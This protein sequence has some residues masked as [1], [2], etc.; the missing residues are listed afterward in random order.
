[1]GINEH[2][3][4]FMDEGW[5]TAFENLIGKADLGNEQA[6]NFFKQFRVAGWA[7]NPGDETQVPIIT[8]VNILSGQAMGHN[9]YGKPALAYLALK[10]MLGD[11]VFRKCLHGFMDRWN[12]KHPVPWDMFNS[13]T[14]LAGK[15]LSWYFNNWFFT[16]NYMD[17][18]ADKVLPT[19]TG[20]AVTVKNIGG[21]AVPTNLFIEYADGS[22]E[23]I[24]QTAGIWEKN[25]QM[26]TVNITTKKKITF[27][28][29]EGGI[30]MDAD[31]KNNTWG[32][33]KETGVKL[34]VA[35]LDKYAGTY[36]SK[37]LPIKIIFTKE[38]DNLM[39]EPTGQEK[40]TLKSTG[41]D[42]FSFEQ[43]GVVIEFDI[44]KNEMTLKQGGGTFLFTKE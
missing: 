33:K 35:D 27:L 39:A 26:T 9:E 36:S 37:Q 32:I 24:H 42:S 30:F 34:S 8:P 2:R 6:D 7:V 41:K 22:K 16:N 20:F 19:K 29:L 28:K 38:G 21:Y 11:E 25:Q 5:T 1:M 18:A 12:S 17:I 23:T 43:A 13:F 10:D 31:D 15:D 3:Y 4:G 40:I 14:N 44:A